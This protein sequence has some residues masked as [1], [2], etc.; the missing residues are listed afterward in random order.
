[1]PSAMPRNSENVP[2]VTMS[3]G[4]PR[5]ATRMAFSAPPAQPV[6]RLDRRSG[7]DRKIPVAIGRPEQNGRE[8]HHRSHRQVDAAGDEDWREGDGQQAELDAQAR[9]LE[10]VAGGREVR[11]DGGE[12]GR[13]RKRVRPAPPTRRWPDHAAR[14]RPRRLHGQACPPASAVWLTRAD[15]QRIDDDGC[16]DDR[17]LYGPLPVGADTEEGQRRSDDAHQDHAEQRARHGPAAAVDRRTADDNGGDHLHLQSESG[18]AR[19]L[20]EADGIEQRRQAGQAAGERKHRKRRERG[21]GHQRAAPRPGSNRWR[22]PPCP[23]AGYAD[24]TR[25]AHRARRR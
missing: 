13:S 18:V 11:R 10:E 23:G 25:R 12:T 4:M 2:S 22:K 1:M 19:N 15:A 7:G 16:E 5:R 14:Q 20:I 24:S 8:S 9:D 21:V 17:A 6:S 3:G